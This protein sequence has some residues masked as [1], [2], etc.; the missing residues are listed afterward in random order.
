MPIDRPIGS[1][2]VLQKRGDKLSDELK[3]FGVKGMKWGVRK[4]DEKSGRKKGSADKQA[5]SEVRSIDNKI[6]ENSKKLRGAIF[7][8][9]N[10]LAQQ[11]YEEGKALLT[12]R[13]KKIAMYVAAGLVVGVGGYM[14]YNN[15]KDFKSTIDFS[16]GYE[17]RSSAN[18]PFG[19]FSLDEF[20]KLSYDESF[21]LQPGHVF[22]RMSLAAETGFN[23]NARFVNR[24]YAAHTEEDATIY[25][26]FLPMFGGAFRRA[27]AGAKMY[28]MSIEAKG[29]V[30]VASTKHCLDTFTELLGGSDERSAKF[31]Q[32]TIDIV[33]LLGAS[34]SFMR[35]RTPDEVHDFIKKDPKEA[36][37]QLYKTFAVGQCLDSEGVAMFFNAM[38]DKGFGAIPDLNDAGRLSKSPLIL[39][40]PDNLKFTGAKIVKASEQRA[41]RIAAAAIKHTGLGL[42]VMSLSNQSEE[43]LQHF[44]VKGMKWGIRK[45]VKMPTRIKDEFESYKR[46]RELTKQLNTVSTLSDAKLRDVIGKA[47]VDATYK[48][49]APRKEYIK[50]HKLTEEEIKKRVDRL[51]LEDNLRQQVSQINAAKR[52]AGIELINSMAVVGAS[53]LIGGT[54]ASTAIAKELTR[55]GKKIGQEQLKKSYLN[56]ETQKIVKR[57]IAKSTKTKKK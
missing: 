34:K 14:V 25:R 43:V 26:G 35:F 28:E 42:E 4:E 27:G 12:E 46:E 29:A 7:S 41:A 16:E 31:R 36:A 9:D 47:R 53:T 6:A 5:L 30:K 39:I 24:L 1:Y 49:L 51:Q 15:V 45:K 18:D 17:K 20:G 21:D 2:L 8:H 22:K 55:V 38:K 57:T 3:H 23:P 10:E 19:D 50:R 48:R 33:N 40:D 54:P 13:N 11:H 32:E 37:R 56:E 52:K 44:G